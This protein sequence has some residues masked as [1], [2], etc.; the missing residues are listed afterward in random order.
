[1]EAAYAQR[2][3]ELAR[4]HWWWRARNAYVTRRVAHLF[5]GITT[6]R[7]LDVGCGDAVLFPFLSRFGFVEGIEPDP[8]VVTPDGPWRH[9]ISLRPFDETFAPDEPYD[10][11]LMLDVVEHLDDPSGA[12]RLAGRLLRPG[13]RILLTVPAFNALWTHHDTINR[14][15]TRFTRSSLRQV[16]DAA[17]LST[18]SSGYLFQWLYAA[19]LVERMKERLGRVTDAPTVPAPAIN[20][21]LYRLCRMEQRLAGTWLPFGSSLIAELRP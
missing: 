18:E 2:Y 19:K 21:A 16:A 11:V 15:H 20:A 17:G 10:L 5:G 6:A 4:D 1:M 9:R 7:I 14:H 13:G 8:L 3:R 12:L